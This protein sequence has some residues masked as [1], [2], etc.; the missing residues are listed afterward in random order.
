[1]KTFKKLDATKGLFP[2]TFSNLVNKIKLQRQVYHSSELVGNDIDKQTKNT[3]ILR[4]I[5]TFYSCNSKRLADGSE[6][7]FPHLRNHENETTFKLCYDLYSISR[8]LFM[9]LFMKLFFIPTDVQAWDVGS[10][11]NLS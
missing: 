2:A 11:Y 6:K 8:L 9:K 5:K 1:M 3:T 7:K 10:Q 4:V